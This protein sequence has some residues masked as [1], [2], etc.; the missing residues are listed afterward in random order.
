[1]KRVFWPKRYTSRLCVWWGLTASVINLCDQRVYLS[2][3]DSRGTAALIFLGA[4]GLAG[5]AD[6]CR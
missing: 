6:S 1:M 4:F 5:L 3:P 2:T